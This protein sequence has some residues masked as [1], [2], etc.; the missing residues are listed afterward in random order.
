M[1]TMLTSQ[2]DYNQL[3]LDVRSAAVFITTPKSSTKRSK[4]SGIANGST[5]RMKVKYRS[6]AIT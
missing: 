1:A 6:P 2:L 5:S 4:R 3:I